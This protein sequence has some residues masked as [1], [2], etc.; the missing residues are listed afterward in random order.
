LKNEIEPSPEDNERAKLLEQFSKRIQVLFEEIS[1]TDPKVKGYFVFGLVSLQDVQPG[2]VDMN[3]HDF[4]FGDGVPTEFI[5]TALHEKMHEWRNKAKME[6][7]YSMMERVVQHEEPQM[8]ALQMLYENLSGNLNGG[9]PTK[10]MMLKAIKEAPTFLSGGHDMIPYVDKFEYVTEDEAVDRIL[11]TLKV[12]TSGLPEFEDG[13]QMSPNVLR[14][15]AEKA[16]IQTK[17]FLCLDTPI[18]ILIHKFSLAIDP[19]MEDER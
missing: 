16:A 7:A 5:A 15:A 9:K 8:R 14:F 17:E 4:V 18:E 6:D 12:V 3:T 13:P 1:R 2:D 19:A 10:N 11:E